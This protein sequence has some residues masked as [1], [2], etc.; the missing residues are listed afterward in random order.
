[1]FG[2][3]ALSERAIASQG[4]MLFGSETLTS[5]F[6]LSGNATPVFTGVLELSGTMDIT[7]SIGVGIMSGVLTGDI[8][9][10]QTSDA[11]A[12]LSGAQECI[13]SFESSAAANKIKVT[14]ASL[15]SF[16]TLSS[17]GLRLASG[18]S[19]LITSFTEESAGNITSVGAAESSAN[20]TQES[21]SIVIRS[22]LSTQSANFTKSA[23]GSLVMRGVVPAQSSFTQS[24]LGMAV[25][26]G[27]SG[28]EFLFIQTTDGAVLW[29]VLNTS[30]PAENWTSMASSTT[31]TWVDL[32][33]STNVESWNNW[34]R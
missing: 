22:A 31:E 2:E 25:Y 19:T 12:I 15:D 33:T 32:S 8:N 24:T 18:A 1:M 11:S 28:Q 10:T 13:S 27:I 7:A 5:D 9:F 17:D 26:S 14:E 20:F 34:L 23:L 16:F 21:A 29:T 30:S 3:L 4:V 6:E